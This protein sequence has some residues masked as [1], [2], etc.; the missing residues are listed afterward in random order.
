MPGTLTVS[1]IINNVR[2]ALNETTTTMLTNTELT[3]MENDGYKDVCAKGFAYEKK[4][5][6]DN[7]S[8][9]Q[10]IISLVGQHIVRINYVEYKSGTTQGGSGMMCTP[11]TSIGHMPIPSNAPWYWFQWGEY[12]IVE[13]LPDVATYDLEVYATCFPSAVLVATTADIPSSDI[14]VEFHED[15][16]LF[17]NAF[18]CLKLGRWSDLSAYYNR[19]I[20]SVLMKKEQYILKYA[21][22]KI[23][24]E[25]PES[26]KVGESNG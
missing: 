5:T 1:N 3:I 18:A 15:I 19:Y 6:K 13:P 8:A 16:E 9:D 2:S 17:T 10:K 7:I 21:D 25:I 11:P 4:I 22:S 23:S 12:L 14:A 26:V 20:N 24:L